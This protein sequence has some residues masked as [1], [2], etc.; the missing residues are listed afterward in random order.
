[1]LRLHRGGEMMAVPVWFPADAE[2]GEGE[3]AARDRTI[4]FASERLY[5]MREAADRA[6]G[7]LSPVVHGLLVGALALWAAAFT[8]A[9]RSLRRDGSPGGDAL[10]DDAAERPAATQG[11]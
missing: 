11:R 5:L 6:D 4:D 1:M 9:V 8:T 10:A 7:V 3:I 2:I